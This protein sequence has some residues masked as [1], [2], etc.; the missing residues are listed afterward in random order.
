MK[1]LYTKTVNESPDLI[2]AYSNQIPTKHQRDIPVTELRCFYNILKFFSSNTQLNI[3]ED[4]NRKGNFK[5]LCKIYNDS[6]KHFSKAY[7]NSNESFLGNNP[8][9]RKQIPTIPEILK[10]TLDATTFFE[11]VDI[12]PV[13][14]NKHL[15]F[16]YVEREVSTIRTTKSIFNSG[17]SGKSSGT[18]GLDFIGLN[19]NDRLPILGEVKIDSDKNAFYALIQLLTYLSEIITA[20]QIKRINNYN[21]FGKDVE[22]NENTKFYLYIILTE[23]KGEHERIFSET[24]KLAENLKMGILDIQNIVFLKLDK[25]T[26][27]IN[28]IS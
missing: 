16:I 14:N 28:Q 9:I 5:N 24:I 21:L 23:L 11:S 25:K 8:E 2:K 1:R 4:F 6:K 26:K 15:D 22:C 13:D 17:K 10:S 7:D 19:S 27:K 3:S 12:V 18:G 20:S